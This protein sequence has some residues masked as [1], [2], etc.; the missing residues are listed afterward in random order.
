M[1]KLIAFDMDGTLLNSKKKISFLTKRYLI[2]LTKQ[3]HKIILASG[4][5]SR[6]LLSYY[7]ELKLDTPVICYNGAYTFSPSDDNFTSHE[8]KFPKDI[9]VQ[10]YDGIKPY[11]DNV[12]C[13][14]DKEIF[15]DKEDKYLGK[16]FWFDNMIIHV[17]PINNILDKDPMTM[18]A[19]LKDDVKDTSPIDKIVEKFEGLSVRYWTG[20]PYFELFFNET[21][22]GASIE[23]IAEHYNIKKEDIIVFGDAENDVEMFKIA[24]VSIAMSNGKESLK[25]HASYVT[26]KDND[27]NGIYH[28]LK[29]YF[30]NKLF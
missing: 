10:I 4:R 28:T 25:K 2:R 19:K 6:A 18:I 12:M 3:G 27:H 5:P 22:K 8:F 13:E 7:K 29:V 17:G 1:T 26:K 30:N 24:G 15:V 11:I 20:S 21:S 16:F 14:T 23:K 9:L